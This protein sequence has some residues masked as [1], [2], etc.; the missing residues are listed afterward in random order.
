MDLPEPTP[1]FLAVLAVEVVLYLGGIA[2]LIAWWKQC[3]KAVG[4]EARADIGTL[5]LALSDL[6]LAAFTIVVGALL[7]QSAVGALAQVIPAALSPEAWMV[8][9]GC[10]FQLGLLSGA[11]L[12]HRLATA[13][14]DRVTA[15]PCRAASSAAR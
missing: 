10:G 3:R 5:N 9:Q 14:N 12:G 13:S 8:A 4:A 6:L 11:L 7:L 1:R 15:A 2:S